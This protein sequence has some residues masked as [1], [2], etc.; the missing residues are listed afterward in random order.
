MSDYFPTMIEDEEDFEEA[1]ADD[2]YEPS[3]YE[4]TDEEWEA[5][6]GEDEEDDDYEGDVY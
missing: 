4:L 3:D 1:L 5:I 2:L 6:F